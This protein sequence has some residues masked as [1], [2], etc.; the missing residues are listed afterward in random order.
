MDSLVVAVVLVALGQRLRLRVP[1]PRRDL[2]LYR[3]RDI[4]ARFRAER[5]PFPVAVDV[6]PLRPSSGTELVGEMAYG[7]VV[8]V[9]YH[10]LFKYT[11]FV[12]MGEERDPVAVPDTVLASSDYR[13]EL[14]HPG[15]NLVSG[16]SESVQNQMMARARRCDVE[17]GPADQL[18]TVGEPLV[19]M[20]LPP[21][22]RDGGAADGPSGAAGGTAEGTGGGAGGPMRPP[23]GRGHSNSPY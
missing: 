22:A 1:T 8:G 14:Y 9:R 2:P 3:S 20:P 13:Y 4:A 19:F 6:R 15:D 23:H 21:P 12:Q 16:L 10:S 18:E 5:R 11:I 17:Q 7:L